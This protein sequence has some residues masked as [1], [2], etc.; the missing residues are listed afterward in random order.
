MFKDQRS[1]RKY[2]VFKRLS[3]A[4][5]FRKTVSQCKS[6]H[7]KMMAYTNNEDID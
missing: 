6:H 1:K 3:E 4:L 7:Q 2:K 5:S